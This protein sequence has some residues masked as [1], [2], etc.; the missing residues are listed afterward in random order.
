MKI[1]HLAQQAQKSKL[2]IGMGKRHQRVGEIKDLLKDAY[3][4]A[5]IFLVERKKK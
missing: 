1:D 5:A 3:R 4:A 2:K